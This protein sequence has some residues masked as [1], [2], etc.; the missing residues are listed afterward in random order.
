MNRIIRITSGRVSTLAGNNII[1]PCT[2][3]IGGRSQEGYLDGKA[4]SALFNSPKGLTY[5]SKGNLFFADTGNHSIR[6]L[7]P[8]GMVTTFAK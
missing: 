2:Q 1:D 5:D 6:K 4:L 3:N 7:S 8:D